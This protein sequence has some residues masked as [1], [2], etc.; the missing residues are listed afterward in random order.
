MIFD[1]LKAYQRSEHFIWTDDY[2]SQNMLTAHLDLSS[3][4]ASRNINTIEKTIEWSLDKTPQGKVLDLGCGPG[5]YASL[6]A[7]RGFSITGIDISER[8]ISYAKR[9]AAEENL[10]IDYQ[11]KDYIKDDIGSGYDVAICIYCD[12]GALT[13]DEQR[14]LLKKIYNGLNKDGVFI[15]DV[16]QAG[17]CDTMQAKRDWRYSDG[18]DFW[19]D[20]PHF[21]LEEVKHF[22]MEKLWGTRNIVIEAGKMP[23]EYITWDRYYTEDEINRL[24]TENGFDII[25]INDQLVAKNDF[26]SNDVMFIKAK[27][28]I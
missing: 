27:K 12:F 9:K 28:R 25:A 4:V 22:A 6:L 10:R 8:S 21:L 19:C 24:L 15:F 18:A 3:D 1:D 17:L 20:K 14:C 16:F 23:R 11:C 5:L 7:K 26:A 2:I 13:S